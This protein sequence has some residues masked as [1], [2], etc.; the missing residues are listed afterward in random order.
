M[1]RLLLISTLFFSH[2]HAK[3][4][5]PTFKFRSVGFVNDFVVNE[6]RLYAANDE[7]TIDIFDIKTQKIIN[8]IILPPITTGLNRI[9]TPNIIS[10]DYFNGKV[11]IVSIGQNAFRNV[12]IYENYELKQIIDEEKKLTIKEARF[13]NDEQII[14]GTFGSEIILHDTTEQYNIYKS[15]ISMSTMGD[16]TL[17]ADKTKMVMSDESGE[18][19]LIDVKSSKVEKTFSSQ[20]VDNVYRVA[21]NSGVIVTAGQDR[22]VAVYQK[23]IPDYHL[24]SSFLVYCVGLSPDGKTGVYSSGEEHNLQIFNTK[25]K[26]KSDILRGHTTIPTQ[27]RFINNKE[28][29]SSGSRHTI[30][31]W[32]LY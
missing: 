20:N 28:L 15:H 18:V 12:W 3:D 6:D 27:I 5:H 13:T 10:V 25:T 2:L 9:K 21:Y 32:K 24:K 23:N 4:I 30:F 22:R 17:S 14:F 11:L 7:G 1:Y 31:Y 16:I 8:Q 26:L 19:Q 29:F